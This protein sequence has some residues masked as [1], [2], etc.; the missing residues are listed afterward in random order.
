MRQ[1][2]GRN[3]VRVKVRLPR[4]QRTRQYDLERLLVRTPQGTDAPLTQIAEI[5]HG[6]A[7]TIIS[8]R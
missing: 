5:E 8:R 7:Y 3:E 6:R 4:R 1:Q 2:R